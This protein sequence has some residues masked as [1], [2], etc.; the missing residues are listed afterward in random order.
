M[1]S[2]KIEYC[3]YQLIKFGITVAGIKIKIVL[4]VKETGNFIVKAIY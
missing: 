2:I 4:T 1:D 3:F